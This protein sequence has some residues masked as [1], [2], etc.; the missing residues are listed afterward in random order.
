METDTGKKRGSD[1]NLCMLGECHLNSEEPKH[2]V[3]YVAIYIWIKRFFEY[4]PHERLHRPESLR[5]CLNI[6]LLLPLW[7][8][9]LFVEWFWWWWDSENPQQ[10]K[11]N[12]EIHICFHPLTMPMHIFNNFGAK[13]INKL[14]LIPNHVKSH[15]KEFLLKYRNTLTLVSISND[16][17]TIRR[18]CTLKE[19]KRLIEIS[20]SSLKSMCKSKWGQCSSISVLKRRRNVL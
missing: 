19:T 1:N 18:F 15:G 4:L 17:R 16:L 3:P 10:K 11:G 6:H 5:D 7:F 9:T 13:M 20:Y 12:N 14:R 2:D 8:L